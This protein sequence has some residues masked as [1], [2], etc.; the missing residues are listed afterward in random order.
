[1]IHGRFSEDTARFDRENVVLRGPRVVRDV[2]SGD[3]IT[4]VERRADGIAGARRP[5]CLVFSTERGFVRLWHYPPNWD[6]LTDGELV[7]L[8]ERPRLSQSA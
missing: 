8:S 6:D 1:M 4:V 5:A 3:T 2:R 7:A